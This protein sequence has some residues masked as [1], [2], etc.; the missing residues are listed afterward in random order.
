MGQKDRAEKFLESYNEVFADIFNV[1]VFK[2]KWIREEN[3]HSLDPVSIYKATDRSLGL[4]QRDI[5]KEYS[6]GRFLIASLGIENQSG[7]DPDMP[8]RVMGYDYATYRDQ[9][10]NSS[11]RV[12]V[13]TIILNF[14][15]QEWKSPLSLKEILKD[16]PED[17]EPFVQDYKL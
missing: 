13:I 10:R 1:L 9:I 17:L 5:L 7:I 6:S 12:P 11:K 8:I 16:M 14:S 2:K 4:Q 15:K 3:L